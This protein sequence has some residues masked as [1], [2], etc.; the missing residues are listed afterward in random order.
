MRLRILSRYVLKEFV[1]PLGLSLVAFAVVFVV[2]DLV[3][4]LSAFIDRDAGLGSLFVYY[5]YYLPEIAVLVLPMAVLLA[6]LFC[7]GGLIQRGELLAMKAAGVSLYQVVIPLQVFAL[8]VSLFAIVLADQVV[9][10]A[11]RAR[12]RIEQPRQSKVGPR[13]IRVQVALRDTGGRIFSMGEYDK[14]SMQGRQV[15]ID[16]YRNGSL[17]ERV[18]AEEAIWEEFEW[19]LINGDLRTFG[20]KR[21]SYASFAMRIARD[22]TLRPEDFA[23]DV[24]PEDQMTYS[25][26]AEFIARKERNG[27]Q[28]LRESVTLHLRLAFPFA[29]F[30]IALFGLPMA[31]RMRRSG[32]PLQIGMC[33]LICFAFYGCIQLGRAMGWNDVVAPFWGAWSANFLFGAIGIVLLLTTRK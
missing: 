27:G 30:V 18:R 23:R 31:S 13:S 32:R 24:L 20:A 16:R 6:G 4:R 22:V 26:L 28:A 1:M 12:G 10:R 25:E 7:M 33:L 11:N 19:H 5:A 14:G 2:I 3:D 17:V 15:V 8:V 9:P 21:A 29:N